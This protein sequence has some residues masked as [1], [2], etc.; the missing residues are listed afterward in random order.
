MNGTVSCE[1]TESLICCVLILLL[2]GFF[3]VC[4][5]DKVKTLE[6]ELDEERTG[7]ELLND[8]IAR[9]RDQVRPYERFE[10]ICKYRAGLLCSD[11]TNTQVPSSSSSQVDQLRSDLMQ[12]RSARHDLEMDKSA[13]ERQVLFMFE[14]SVWPAQK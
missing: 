11:R 1:S 3:F 6:I 5:Q 12:E 9:N 2:S 4:L 14:T 7:V 10:Y 13:L 8:R